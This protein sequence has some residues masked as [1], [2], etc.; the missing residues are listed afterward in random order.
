MARSIRVIA[1]RSH[2]TGLQVQLVQAVV[3]LLHGVAVHQAGLGD[4]DAGNRQRRGRGPGVIISR[5]GFGRGVSDGCEC[6]VVPTVG[7][8]HQFHVQS[9]QV[10][11]ADHQGLFH[12]QWPDLQ[13]EPHALDTG[14][15]RRVEARRVAQRGRT[16][17]DP[18][19]RQQ[20]QPEVALD[21]EGPA[22]LLFNRRGN[23]VAI[24]VRIHE[25]KHRDDHGQHEDHRDA[26]QA[27]GQFQQGL[28]NRY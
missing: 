18:A 9:L 17:P 14:E 2:C 28:H 1:F 22:R 21:G 11:L 5:L 23:L 19:T 12:Q 8:A 3:G 4:I 20:G 10:D 6:P 7:P 13:P 15:L 26:Q 25:Q 24:V 27:Q 16:K